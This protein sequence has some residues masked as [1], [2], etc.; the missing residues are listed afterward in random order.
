MF[1]SLKKRQEN[2]GTH[3]A[4]VPY[5][6]RICFTGIEK[7]KKAYVSAHLQTSSHLFDKGIAYRKYCNILEKFTSGISLIK[8]FKAWKKL[9]ADADFCHREQLENIRAKVNY[10]IARSIR[11]IDDIGLI[12]IYIK[13]KDYWIFAMGL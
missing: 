8:E 10:L 13:V 3:A 11:T 4:N 12:L 6:L 9:Q 5:D 2:V 7:I 1:T